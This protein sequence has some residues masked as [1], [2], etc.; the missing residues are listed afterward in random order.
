MIGKLTGRVDE[1]SADHALIDVNGVGYIAFCG[2]G[3]LGKLVRGDFVSLHIETQVREDAIRL[4]GFATVDERDWFRLLQTVQGVGAK[5]ALAVLSIAAP[6]EISRSIA[7][8]DKSL[9]G[10]A[11][12]VGP[13]LAAR[14]VSELKDKV[15]AMIVLPP[16]AAA[17]G[18]A[19]ARGPQGPAAEAV[20]ALVNLGYAHLEAADAVTAALAAHGEQAKLDVLIREG[21]KEL[22]R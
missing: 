4:F 9:I 12:G 17:G 18:R 3:T 16:P 7:L 13:K 21:L 14:I 1:V 20:S 22:A 6:S 10:R 5:V 15:P 19:P 2:A 11:A 8:Q